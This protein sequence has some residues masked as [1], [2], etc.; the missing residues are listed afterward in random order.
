[1]S[2]TG[3]T[4]APPTSGLRTIMNFEIPL[5]INA[6]GAIDPYAMDPLTR[7]KKSRRLGKNDKRF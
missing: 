2:D 3:R 4:F 6:R 1:M 5:I 7:P